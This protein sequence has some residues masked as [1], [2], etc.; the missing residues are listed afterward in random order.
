MSVSQHT[1]TCVCVCVHMWACELAHQRRAGRPQFDTEGVAVIM[2]D[3]AR[4]MK[5]QRQLVG[6]VVVETLKLH[7][8]SKHSMEIWTSGPNHGKPAISQN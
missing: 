1:H 6:D 8:L 5:W 4:S 3:E 2:A 7:T